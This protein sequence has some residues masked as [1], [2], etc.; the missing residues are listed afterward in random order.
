MFTGDTPSTKKTQTYTQDHSKIIYL[1]TPGLYDSKVQQTAANEI[2]KALKKNGSFQ[3]FFVVTMKSGKIRPIDLTSMW[4][5]LMNALDIKFFGIIINKLSKEDYEFLSQDPLRLQDELKGF[6]SFLLLPDVGIPNN[7]SGNFKNK[8]LE[9]FVAE[10]QPVDIDPD[11]V[12]KIPDDDISFQRFE[13]ILKIYRFVSLTANKEKCSKIVDY[14]KVALNLAVSFIYL[15][16][17][18]YLFTFSSFLPFQFIVLKKFLV[19]MIL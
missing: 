5:V 8:Q 14:L 7:R 3:V 13:Q 16:L 6:T 4:L 12:N 9:K 1:D 2:T 18:F 15:L 19:M 17:T 10:V 11:K